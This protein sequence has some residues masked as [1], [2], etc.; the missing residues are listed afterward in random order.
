VTV[1]D[2]LTKHQPFPQAIVTPTT[3]EES[4]REITPQNLVSEGWVTKEVYDQMAVK[5]Q[6]LFAVGA[7]LLAEKSIIWLIPSTSLVCST[8]S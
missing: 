8:E 6:M 2:G 4:D 7:Q 3:K 1:P 5:A